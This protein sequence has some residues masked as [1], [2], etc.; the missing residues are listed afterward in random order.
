[1]TSGDGED[2]A[3]QQGRC[4]ALIAVHLFDAF[5]AVLAAVHVGVFWRAGGVSPRIP[6]ALSGG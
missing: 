3:R 6:R 2:V 1:M 4:L 5:L